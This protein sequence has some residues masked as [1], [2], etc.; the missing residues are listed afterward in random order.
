[1]AASFAAQLA[2]F[3]LSL[4]TVDHFP[5]AEGVVYLRPDPSP[6]LSRAHDLLHKLLGP[7]RRLVHTYY[8]PGAWHPHCTM[9]INVPPG[10][11]NAV[12]F[13]C[14]SPDVVGDVRVTRVQVV[15]YRPATEISE[16]VLGPHTTL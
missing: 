7:Q 16:A 14:Q 4:A 10:L 12:V 11:I 1:V 9:A 2:P 13:E 8:Q 5:T 3:G 15:Q 6:A